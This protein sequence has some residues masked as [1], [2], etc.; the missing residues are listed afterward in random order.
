[1]NLSNRSYTITPEVEI[2]QDGGEGM[3]VTDGGASA[4]TVCTR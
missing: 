2:P 3:I 1:M 4:V